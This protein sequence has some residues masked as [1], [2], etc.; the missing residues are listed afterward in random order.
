MSVSRQLNVIS[1]MRM[2]VPHI[3]LIESGVAGDFDTVVG[4]GMAGGAGL[5]LRGF[6][7]AGA[8]NNLANTLHLVTADGIAVNLHASQSGSFLWVPSTRASELLDGA[9]NGR[10]LGAFVPSAVNYV[11]LDFVRELDDSTIDLVKFKDPVTSA[12]SDRL[13]PLGKVLNYKIVISTSPFSTQANVIPLAKVTVSSTGVVTAIA[14]ARQMMYRL[15]SG[16]DAPNSLSSYSW[17][18]GRLEGAFTGADKSFT[19]QKEWS[20][21]VMTRLWELGGGQNW[22]APTA[23]RNVHQINYGSPFANGDYMTFNSGTGAVSWQG[24]SLLFDGGTAGATAND[25][26]AG[27]GIILDGQCLYVDLDR[28]Q[29][30]YD[31]GN[32]IFASITNLSTLGTGTTP[33][34]RWVL[35]WRV[36][37]SLF[38]RG[39]R[40]PVGTTFTPATTTAMGVVKL[41][42]AAET[43]LT[44][45]VIAIQASGFA[46]VTADGTGALGFAFQAGFTGVRAGNFSR[47]GMKGT[48]ADNSTAN[49]AGIGVLG[50]GGNNSSNGPGGTGVQGQGGTSVTGTG[51][52]G[53]NFTG[54][55]GSIFGGGI[56]VEGIGVGPGSG[57]VGTAAGASGVKG[58]GGATF[59]GVEG[60]GGA[61]SGVGVIGTATAGNSA[62]VQGTGQGG[63]TGVR[64]FGGVTGYGVYGEGADG[65]GVFHSLGANAGIIGLNVAGG[66]AGG[67]FQGDGAGAGLRAFGGTTSGKGVDA[68]GGAPNGIG[69]YGRG[70]GNG[71]GVQGSGQA[72]TTGAGGD[73]TGGT[74][75]GDG[76]YGTGKVAGSGVIGISGATVGDGVVGIALGSGFGV[77]SAAGPVGAPA[78]SQFQFTTTKTGYHFLSVAE[79]SVAGTTALPLDG[80]GGTGGT[81][82]AP[83]YTIT[84]AN[85]VRLVG[86]LHLPR[87]ATITKVLVHVANNSVGTAYNINQPLIDMFTY[88]ATDHAVMTRTPVVGA[89]TVNVAVSGTQSTTTP[90][91]WIPCVV[92][93]VVA[94][95]C[96]TAIANSGACQVDWNINTTPG[97]VTADVAGIMFEY[98][99][100]T[101]DFGL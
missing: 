46:S 28:T 85:G 98:T 95:T 54:G 99:Y 51:G 61:T 97:G 52:S 82:V 26:A 5:I 70:T 40:Y 44:P 20:D 50:A 6:T 90:G 81:L 77:K 89:A 47:S 93:A 60:I 91:Y 49:G 101:V 88:G 67:Y 24:I 75:G 42:A 15:G 53:G 11:G 100:T 17:P 37:G 94:P 59:A 3:R 76:V 48:G 68:Y 78:A 19:S 18:A 36:S 29:N 21:A 22:F 1:Q 62:G 31:P 16:G 55:T 23:D 12:E 32:P 87:G 7:I 39:W 57:V 10:V 35:A 86:T 92:A 74:A 43:P 71:P 30:R 63:G 33:G 66:G 83:H 64:G 84:A 80:P 73:F 2:D 45:A 69:V 13:V 14:D 41:N 79:L 4:R 8:V 9:S 25:V 96:S 38:Q 56:G 27:S 72:A 58:T 34:S 65:G